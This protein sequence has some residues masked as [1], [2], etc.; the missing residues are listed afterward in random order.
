MFTAEGTTLLPGKLVRSEGQKRT[1]DPATDEAYDGAGATYD[2]YREVFGRDS[3]DGK[4]MRLDSTVHFG[5]DYDNAFWNGRQMVYGDG[6]GELFQRFTR[7]LDVI[8]HE[9]THGVVQFEADL[10]Y[11]GESGALAESFADVFGALVKQWRLGQ[12]A[13]EADWLVGKGLFTRKVKGRAIRSMKAPGSAYD[14]PVLGKDPQPGHLRD[15]VETTDDNGGVHVNSGIPNRAF[16]ETAV[17]L[18]GHAWMGAGRIWYDAMVS[19]L[20][21]SSTFR[22]AAEATAAEAARRF[23]TRSVEADAV[24]AGWSAVGVAAS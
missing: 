10:E 23:G 24:R 17:R 20:R 19:R 8:G 3:V 11:Q 5:R 7:A 2:F 15:L 14:D 16:Y 6:D 13:A 4:G 18:G 12:T 22:E 21:G 1:G 9:L